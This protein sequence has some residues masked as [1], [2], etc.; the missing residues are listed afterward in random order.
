MFI[1]SARPSKSE[2]RLPTVGVV[3]SLKPG[4]TASQLQAVARIVDSAADARRKINER[5]AGGSNI[6]AVT[7]N[8]SGGKSYQEQFI[9]F[10]ESVHYGKQLIAIS[11]PF[12]K[13]DNM[14]ITSVTITRDNQRNALTF[15]LTAQKFRIAKTLF[16][17]VSQ[18]YRKPAPAVKSQTAG[19]ADK[20]AQ[21]PTSGAGTTK[22][23]K[24]LLTAITGR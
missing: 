10:I 16:S 6:A 23:Q 9:D 1:P 2:S 7:G 24:S 12:R 11:M 15:S 19:V 20:G 5:I 22:K 18:F 3:N 14:A 8:N 13:Q 17:S 4:R 21:S